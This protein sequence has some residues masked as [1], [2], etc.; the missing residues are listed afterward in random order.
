[1][2]RPTCSS[3]NSN[4]YSVNLLNEKEESYFFRDGR[5]MEIA[6]MFISCMV[7]NEPEAFLNK[8]VKERE[9]LLN[10]KSNDKTLKKV[11]IKRD[12][13]TGRWNLNLGFIEKIFLKQP[14]KVVQ[15]TTEYFPIKYLIESLKYY[16]IV[17]FLNP[18]SIIKLLKK[19]E[20]FIPS[21][22]LISHVF[23]KSVL[24]YDIESEIRNNLYP[25]YFFSKL[26]VI[27]NNWK[28]KANLFLTR[29][30][31]YK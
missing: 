3:I 31:V 5:S 18:Y 30:E 27:Q 22:T 25:N 12:T 7:E 15:V 24:S 28:M 17:S 29:S 26:N 8:D 21:K 20:N 9:I 16:E 2:F 6:K 10:C 11:L 13:S 4:F 19:G 1:M 23:M 14:Q